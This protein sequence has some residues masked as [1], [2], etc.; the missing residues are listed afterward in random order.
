MKLG[1]VVGRVVSTKKMPCIEGLKLLLVQPLDHLQQNAGPIIAA[2]DTVKAGE[3]DLIFFESGK[4]AAQ[5]NPNGWFN[6]AD[7]AI[8]GI[9]DAMNTE[10][11]R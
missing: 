9:V 1:R 3:G 5:A 4:E 6:P 2:F 10:E 8:I 11:T 7:A